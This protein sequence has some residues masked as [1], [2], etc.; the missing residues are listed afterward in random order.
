MLVGDHLVAYL[1][2]GHLLQRPCGKR[3]YF[4]WTQSLG[5]PECCSQN[6]RHVPGV[7]T[8]LPMPSPM[9]WLV[10]ALRHSLNSTGLF[11]SCGWKR[12]Y[13]FRFLFPV[14]ES[15]C[16]SEDMFTVKVMVLLCKRS[17]ILFPMPQKELEGKKKINIPPSPSPRNW[18]QVSNYY[19]KANREQSF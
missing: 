7:G 14:L 2:P 9:A 18:K 8:G 17:Q 4:F 15:H 1:F 3:M 5:R 13:I 11:F 19:R 10:L 6:A 12:L 16:F